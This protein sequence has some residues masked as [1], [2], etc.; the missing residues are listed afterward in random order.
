VRQSQ[1][2]DR[3]EAEIPSPGLASPGSQLAVP[4]LARA[5]LLGVLYVEDTQESQFGYDEEDALVAV[6]QHIG[7]AAQ[8]AGQST[9]EEAKRTRRHLRAAQPAGQPISIRHFAADETIFVDDNYLIK[10]VAG[11]ILWKLLREFQASAR[12]EFTNRELRLD[13]SLP[14]PD[15]ST[16]LEARLILL[17]RRLQERCPDLAIESTGRGRFRLR[18]ARPLRLLEAE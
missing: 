4:I 18:V 17:K 7:L 1:L 6:A 13:A 5:Q 11:A 2:A 14:L 15:L 3:L 12:S 9:G 10:G 8:L 16:N